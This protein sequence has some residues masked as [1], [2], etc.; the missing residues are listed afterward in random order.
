MTRV[1]LIEPPQVH[2]L[3][4]GGSSFSLGLAYIA[5]SLR[6]EGFKVSLLHCF[7]E[8]R[9]QFVHI[10][11]GLYRIGLSDQQICAQVEKLNP[12]FIGISIGISRQYEVAVHVASLIGSN[13]NET[14]IIAGGAHVSADPKSLNKTDFD[15]LVVGE[16][17]ISFPKLI[18]AI[19]EKPGT[20]PS[21]AGTYFRDQNH[22][23]T[24]SLPVELVSN[25]DKLPFPAFDLLHL[26]K[27][28]EKQV[29]YANIMATRGCPHKC[30]FCSIHS[31]MGR[32]IRRRSIENIISEIKLLV[33]KYGVREIFFIDDN[34]TSNMSWAKKLFKCLASLKLNIEIG[35]RN[36]I[37]ADRIDKELLSLMKKAGCSRISFAPESGSQKTLDN[38]IG[39][40]LRLEKVEKAVREAHS[41]GLYVTCLFVIGFPGE[42]ISDMQQT[43]GFAKELRKIG[44]D[45]VDIN[46][47][48]PYPGTFLYSKCMEEGL[49]NKNIDYA[50]LHIGESMI[51]TADFKPEQV[52]S[53]RKE[54]MRDLSENYANKLK[55]GLRAFVGQPLLYTQRKIRRLMASI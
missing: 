3:S 10:G 1:L 15:Y 33:H 12:D 7:L 52:M 9:E 27:A 14:V 50:R 20:N 38:I 36:G 49:I 53:L 44:C 18:H 25:L 41:V 39:K 48:T 5:S 21:V 22:T 29:P 40:R 16:G 34:L 55:R 45:T 54:A 43:I 11:K 42:T 28:W 32:K 24:P 31:V 47:A 30:C 46:C 6:N 8:G 51:S 35:V 17:E 19:E 4:Q 37:R 2:T 26:E 23:F 13:F